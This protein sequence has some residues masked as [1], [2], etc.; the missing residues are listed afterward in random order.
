[1]Q[2]SAEEK[3][4]E[5]V[6]YRVVIIGLGKRRFEYKLNIEITV[7]AVENEAGGVNELR[8]AICQTHNSL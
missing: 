5:N 1:M 3:V 4:V 2:D 7:K 8:T 6:I